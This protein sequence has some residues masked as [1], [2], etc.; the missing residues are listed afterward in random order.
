MASGPPGRVTRGTHCPRAPSG[1]ECLAPR[2]KRSRL[3]RPPQLRRDERA[4][5]PAAEAHAQDRDP[6]EDLPRG[7]IGD[8]LPLPPGVRPR[9]CW[10]AA[11]RTLDAGILDEGVE[12]GLLPIDNGEVV[13]KLESQ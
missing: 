3:H 13:T 8:P 9:A 6:F 1:P 7:Q 11:P 10:R 2:R 12:I 4:R 5:R